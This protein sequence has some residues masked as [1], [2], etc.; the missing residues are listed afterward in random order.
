MPKASVVAT[1]ATVAFSA[2]MS[3][4][5]SGQCASPLQWSRSKCTFMRRTCAI[6]RNSCMRLDVRVGFRRVFSCLF[7]SDRTFQRYVA[8]FVD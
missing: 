7:R 3:K 6:F 1:A 2:D 8:Y 5:A 4:C